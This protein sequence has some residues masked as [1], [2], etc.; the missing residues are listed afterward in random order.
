MNDNSPYNPGFDKMQNQKSDWRS[1]ESSAA[2]SNGDQEH[3]EYNQ[4]RYECHDPLEGGEAGNSSVLGQA[5]EYC[6]A[7]RGA[8]KK[9]FKNAEERLQF[10][11]Q[12]EA[13]KKTELCR[14]FEM[15]G[16]CKFG[17][18]CSYAHG[19]QQLQKKTHLPSNFMT[20]LCT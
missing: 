20:K 4:I 18:D 9:Q 10:K 12:Y 15:Y 19:P 11:Q 2:S 14:N 16:Q 5:L 6:E 3:Q 17:N 7:T 13:K 1:N 8:K